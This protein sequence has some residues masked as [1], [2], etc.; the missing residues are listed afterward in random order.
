MAFSLVHADKNGVRINEI[1]LDR[2]LPAPDHVYLD[3][4]Y[5]MMRAAGMIIPAAGFDN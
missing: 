2:A 4:G 1:K 5:R 3:A